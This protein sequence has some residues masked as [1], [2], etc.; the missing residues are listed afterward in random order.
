MNTNIPDPAVLHGTAGKDAVE[1]TTK[2]GKRQVEVSM[3]LYNGK[4][5]SGEYKPST[6]IRVRAYGDA[7]EAMAEIRK[8]DRVTAC[9]QLAV[10]T[11]TDREGQTRTDLVLTAFRCET[12]AKQAPA[13]P[14]ARPASRSAPV[15][16]PVED[17]EEIPF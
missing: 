11:W 12:E 9:G 1:R 8:G 6:W 13:R 7:A 17:D 3:A 16:R 10:E 5:Q 2:N 14:A 15:T 4:E